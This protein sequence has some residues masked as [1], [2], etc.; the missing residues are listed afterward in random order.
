LRFHDGILV[1][2]VDEAGRGSIIG[3]LV[4]A[5]V[6]IR[7]SKISLLTEMGVKDSKAL[8]PRAR[9]RLF[10]E[11]MKVADS[12]CI[13]KIN[14]VEVDDSVS[15]KGLNR[16]EAKVMASVINNIGADEVYIDCCD[17]NPDRYRDH[18]EQHL[19]CS[20]KVHSMHHADAIN[21][22]VSA[23]SIIAKITRD[24]EVQHIRARYRSIGSGYPS[25]EQTMRFIRRWVNKN[26]AAP[27]FARKSWKPLRLML[28]Q[29]AQSK[30]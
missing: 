24:H 9:A 16:L 10:G 4:V 30:F 18:I 28:E 14:P 5:G 26:G 27:E 17:V 21:I 20:P 6:S 1:G 12:V 7:E 8:T 25:D 19:K 29:M 3:P 22:V 11:I 2:G 13:R 15:L 23:A